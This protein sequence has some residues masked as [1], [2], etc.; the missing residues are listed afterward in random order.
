M[1]ALV[2]ALNDK[3]VAE[4]RALAP[5]MQHVYLPTFHVTHLASPRR[6]VA[7]V[8]RFAQSIEAPPSRAD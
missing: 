6:F 8:T 4:A 5:G 7:E 1:L 3:D 2:G